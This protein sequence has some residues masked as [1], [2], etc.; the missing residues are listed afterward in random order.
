M[1]WGVA[2]FAIP[3]RR[4]AA[5]NDRLRRRIHASDGGAVCR[6]PAPRN[7]APAERSCNGLTSQLTNGAAI[8]IATHQIEPFIEKACRVVTVRDGTCSVV[9][10]LPAD[11]TARVTLVE[12]LSAGSATS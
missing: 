5:L 3:A 12:R 6:F 11:R 1:V 7:G 9:E 4:T 10:P 8:V 2:G